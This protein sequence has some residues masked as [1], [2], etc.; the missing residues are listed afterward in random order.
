V[1]VPVTKEQAAQLRESVQSLLK[2][3][4]EKQKAERPKRWDMMEYRLSGNTPITCRRYTCVHSTTTY[5]RSCAAIEFYNACLHTLMWTHALLLHAPHGRVLRFSIIAV[6]RII[7]CVYAID[8]SFR[9]LHG[10]QADF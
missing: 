7:V 10:Y 8:S 1:N 6:Y 2:T 3:F 9:I 5:P 4:A